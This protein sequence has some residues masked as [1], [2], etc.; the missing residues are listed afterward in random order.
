MKIHGH[1]NLPRTCKRHEKSF[2]EVDTAR[3]KLF[4]GNRIRDSKF[5]FR[6]RRL[7]AV[8]K[9]AL[10]S[11]RRRTAMMYFEAIFL[12]VIRAAVAQNAGIAVVGGVRIRWL[13]R[14]SSVKTKWKI[15]WK[16]E[17][18]I[19]CSCKWKLNIFQSEHYMCANFKFSQICN[20]SISTFSKIWKLLHFGKILK[21]W[22][23]FS[24]KSANIQQSSGKICNILWKSAKNMQIWPQNWD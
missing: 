1:S 19:K 8:A 15:K 7:S 23:T 13:G 22:S 24:R 20:H 21:N 17:W 5:D 4:L 11:F 9:S 2:A 6:N 18:K 10:D 3:G 12:Q 14:E 16:I